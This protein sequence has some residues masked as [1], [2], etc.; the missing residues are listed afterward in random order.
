VKHAVGDLAV[1]AMKVMQEVVPHQVRSQTAFACYEV[2]SLHGTN[3][4][5]K[6]ARGA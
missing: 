4:A 6:L 2:A 5:C 1:A 3:K